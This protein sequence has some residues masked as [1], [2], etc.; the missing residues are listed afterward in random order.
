M[1][2]CRHCF[3]S[4]GWGVWGY[5]NP[6]NC[7]Q[8]RTCLRCGNAN[9]TSDDR[10]FHLWEA[11]HCSRC[12]I[13][14]NKSEHL[15]EQFKQAPSPTLA[16]DVIALGGEN[17]KRLLYVLDE[18]GKELSVA[19]VYYYVLIALKAV[20]SGKELKATYTTMTRGYDYFEVSADGSRERV[21]FINRN[22][23]IRIMAKYPQEQE[24][25]QIASEEIQ[26]R[27]FPKVGEEQSVLP[28]GN[29]E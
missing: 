20:E 27:E 7:Q 26:Q 18:L 21:C 1:D 16:Q 24:W 4:E 15:I 10:I 5:R 14:K 25:V 12:M 23:Y 6:D 9:P 11:S 22:I 8:Y 17:A 2:V 19:D 3:S 28:N 29:I 13:D